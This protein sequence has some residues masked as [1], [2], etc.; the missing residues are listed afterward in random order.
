VTAGDPPRTA[1][2]WMAAH[3]L[4]ANA[5]TG[6][7]STIVATVF[8][9]SRLNV[10][11]HDVAKRLARLE[12]A[13][14]DLA[15]E[16]PRIRLEL[17]NMYGGMPALAATNFARMLRAHESKGC[18][19]PGGSAESIEKIT[20]PAVR[21]R[22]DTLYRANHVTI[23]IAGDLDVAEVTTRLGKELKS[24]PRGPLA[25]YPSG[26]LREPADPPY[27]PRWRRFDVESKVLGERRRVAMAVPSA[28]PY[29]TPERA[30]ARLVV[31]ARLFAAAAAAGRDPATGAPDTT[32]QFAPLD[33]LEDIVL[34]TVLRSS[35]TP[36][37][38]IERLDKMLDAALLAPTKADAELV[39]KTFGFLFALADFP[40]SALAANPYGVA[41]GLARRRQMGFDPAH[42]R[43]ALPKVTREE[44]QAVLIRSSSPHSVAYVVPN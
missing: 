8:E 43:A 28:L 1:E 41:L 38:A 17:E 5:Q 7:R 14:A 12:V 20:L 35:E 3:P 6:D 34:S 18:E 11:I 2:A 32:I 15:R 24:L 10:E 13:P 33:G 29:A 22:L 23:A 40:E 16:W 42:V 9:P 19:R 25:P 36:E 21:D 4:G 31:A 27:P 30:A 39:V 44:M 26:P 37:Q